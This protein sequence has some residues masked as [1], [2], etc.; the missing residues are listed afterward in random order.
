MVF[1]ELHIINN[2]FENR[3][4]RTQHEFMSS[5]YMLIIRKLRMNAL[6]YRLALPPL[7]PHLRTKTSGTVLKHEQISIFF[8]GHPLNSYSGSGF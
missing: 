2:G 7:C 8:P 4:A 5:E 1:K 6:V 3:A